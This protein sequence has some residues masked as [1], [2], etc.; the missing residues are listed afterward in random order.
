MDLDKLAKPFLKGIRP[1]KPGKPI[2]QLQRER[3]IT[4]PIAK[5]ASNENPYPPCERIKQAVI[6]TLDST[7]RYPESGAP[8]LTEKLARLHSVDA[9]EIFV[10]NGTNEILDLLVRA[11]VY[12]DQNC[13]FSELSFVIYKLICMQCGVGFEEVP[14]R[15]YTHNLDAMADAINDKTRIV[16]VCNPN[17]PTAT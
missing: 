5:L 3:G 2:E 12:S 11:Y 17:N 10:A 16:F 9:E 8:E 7:N 15:D 6:A 4:V 14:C 13:V 1:Y